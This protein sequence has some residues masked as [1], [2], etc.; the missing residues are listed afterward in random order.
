MIWSA[1]IRR[2]P[3]LISYEEVNDWL[4]HLIKERK[5]SASSVNIAVNALRQLRWRIT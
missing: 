2:S 5:Q 1:I 3:Q 4:H